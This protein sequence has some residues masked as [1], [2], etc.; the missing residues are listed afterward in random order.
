MSTSGVRNGDSRVSDQRIRAYLLGELGPAECDVLENE[1]YAE[2]DGALRIEA[3]ECKLIEEYVA[4]QLSPTD[5]NHFDEWF[6]CTDDRRTKLALVQRL[7]RPAASYARTLRSRKQPLSWLQPAWISASALAILIGLGIFAGYEWK[8][9]AHL[10]AKQREWEQNSGE[11]AGREKPLVAALRLQISDINRDSGQ[12]PSLSVAQSIRVIRLTVQLPP[13]TNAVPFR[14][15]LSDFN[16]EEIYVWQQ[17]RTS[18]SPQNTIDLF[19]PADALEPDDYRVSVRVPARAGEY[20][21]IATYPFRLTK[22]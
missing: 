4:K 19:L 5:R 13:A 3:I 6:L 15:V 9:N 10:A 12:S 18:A 20:E 14:A 7:S 2:P 22:K 1:L 21:E 11:I 17:L 16:G 8:E